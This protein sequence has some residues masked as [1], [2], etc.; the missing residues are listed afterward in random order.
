MIKIGPLPNTMID[1][2]D[3]D[4]DDKLNHRICIVLTTIRSIAGWEAVAI[5]LGCESIYDR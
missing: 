4:Y 1:D 2:D 5:G 3:N